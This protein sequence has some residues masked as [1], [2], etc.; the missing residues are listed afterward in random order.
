MLLGMAV[1]MLRQGG[2]VMQSGPEGPD[3]LLRGFVATFVLTATNPI[4]IVAFLG[5]FAF[6]GVAALGGNTMLALAL[7]VG[8]FVGSSIWW[9]SLAALAGRYRAQLA[10]GALRRI[11]QCS[12]LLLLGFGLY[13][14]AS[15]LMR[16]LEAAP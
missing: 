12:G 15:A 10:G 13:G 14:L 7:V 11:N 8:V 1:R 4:T 16:F 5:I 9:L 2:G 3:G 6:F